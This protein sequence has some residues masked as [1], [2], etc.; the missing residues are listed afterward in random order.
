MKVLLRAPLLTNSGYGVHSRQLFKWLDD[1]HDI[2][3]TVECLGW[4]QC[5]WTVHQTKDDCIYQRIMN[6]S[7]PIEKGSYDVTFQVQLPDEWDP[8]LGKK[9]VGVTAAV[10]TDRCYQKWVECCNRMDA[11]I[12]P[13]KFTKNVIKRS[14]RLTTKISVIQEWPDG[15]INSIR[16]IPNS[17]DLDHLYKFP[18]ENKYNFLIMGLLTSNDTSC[19]RKNLIQTMKWIFEEFQSEPEVGIVLKTSF[20]K[21]TTTDKAF[22]RGYLKQ[23][24]P[25]IRKGNNPVHLIHGNLSTE[26]VRSLYSHPNIKAYAMATRGEGYGLPFIEAGLASLPI[27]ATNWSGHLEFLKKD[28]FFPVDYKLK[29]IPDKKVNERIFM[30]GSKW[31][32]PD[33]VSFKKMIRYVYENQKEAFETA[34]KLSKHIVENFYQDVII[35][36]YDKFLKEISK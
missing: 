13:S 33:E 30:K 27:I 7:K 10:E 19:D 16:D 32:E 20:G 15:G 8:T 3:L 21:G 23:A 9:N 25:V 2:D 1:R 4:G 29:E 22:T 31:A 26:E 12:V 28:L 24:L 14:G 35:E 18:I 5:P 17:Y 11:V 34:E 36:R 6:K